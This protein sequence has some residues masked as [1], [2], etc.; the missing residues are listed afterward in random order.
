MGLTVGIM[1]IEWWIFRAWWDEDTNE[2][3]NDGHVRQELRAVGLEM[4]D[5]LISV[6]TLVGMKIWE[7]ISWMGSGIKYGG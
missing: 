6:S 7:R 3:Y 2:Q 5:E 1:G 4:W